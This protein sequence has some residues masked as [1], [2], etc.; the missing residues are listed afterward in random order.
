MDDKFGTDLAAE[1]GARI[2]RRF[3]CVDT[4]GGCQVTKKPPVV[5]ERFW[6]WIWIVVHIMKQ[7]RPR[8]LSFALR[9]AM[10]LYFPL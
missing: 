4:H 6:K 8:L 3:S 7:F 10:A 5:A 1:L 2:Q 9:S